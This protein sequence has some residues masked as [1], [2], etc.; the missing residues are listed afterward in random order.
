MSL[1]MTLQLRFYAVPDQLIQQSESKNFS[2]RN[3]WLLFL[4]GFKLSL[5]TLTLYYFFIL[6]FKFKAFLK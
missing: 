6:S 5:W 4:T 2:F 1:R 3:L